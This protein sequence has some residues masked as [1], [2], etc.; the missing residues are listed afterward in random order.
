ML[1]EYPLLSPVCY[2]LLY[3]SFLFAAL[4]LRL[5]LVVVLAATTSLVVVSCYYLLLVCL[6][7]PFKN[8]NSTDNAVVFTLSSTSTE[9]QLSTLFS[10][11]SR[12]NSARIP[13]APFE[14]WTFFFPSGIRWPKYIPKYKNDQVLGDTNHLN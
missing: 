5:A 12:T 4:H 13:R 2:L 11:Q 7:F 14:A 9:V 1:S 6:S 10:S 3:S 8:L